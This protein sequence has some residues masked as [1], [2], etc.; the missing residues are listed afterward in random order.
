MTIYSDSTNSFSS[1]FSTISLTISSPPTSSPLMMSC[2]NVGQSF[3]F[4]RPIHQVSQTGKSTTIHNTTKQNDARKLIGRR[5]SKTKERERNAPCRTLSSV[6]MSN[7][8]YSTPC[9]FNIPTIVLEN[10]HRGVSGSPFMNSTTL[11]LVIS[12]FR[13]V[14]SWSSVSSCCFSLKIEGAAG[15]GAG[16][17]VVVDLAWGIDRPCFASSAVSA[18]AS[19]PFTLPRRVCP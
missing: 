14:F 6:N 7:V 8:V 19:A 1:P 2:G 9:S 5:A 18:G 17:W 12:P 11:L 16:D 10:P 13:R 3:N 4:F 15:G